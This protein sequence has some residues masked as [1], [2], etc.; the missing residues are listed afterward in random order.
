MSKK[1]PNSYKS[2]GIILARDWKDTVSEQPVYTVSS[3]I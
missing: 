1:K 2:E 3:K